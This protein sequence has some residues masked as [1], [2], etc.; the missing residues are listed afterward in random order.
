MAT[1]PATE[2]KAH[3]LA[4]LDR[5]SRTGEEITITKRGKPVA[6]LVPPARPAGGPLQH[7]LTGTIEIVGDIV[8]PVVPSIAWEA[9]RGK[10]RQARAR[11]GGPR[12]REA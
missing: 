3:C 8:A 1:L 7:P 5:V 11:R 9:A 10:P 2:F 6:R 4:V 12:R